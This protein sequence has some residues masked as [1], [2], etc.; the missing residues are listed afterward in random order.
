ME[1]R[2]FAEVDFPQ[3]AEIYQQGINTQI[4][5]FETKVPKWEEWDNSHIKECRIASFENEK[6]TAWA[7]LTKVSG[8]CVYAGVAESKC[9]RKR[10]LQ[11]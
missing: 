10:K 11:R 8:R 3:V 9:L 4:A 6:M 2:N 5:T 7:S 1:I